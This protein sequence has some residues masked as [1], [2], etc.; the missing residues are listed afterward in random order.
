MAQGAHGTQRWIEQAKEQKT[1]I[2]FRQQLASGVLLGWRLD[3]RRQVGLQTPAK[4]LEQFPALQIA[5]FNRLQGRGHAPIK[6]YCTNLY[7]LQSSYGA[8]TNPLQN[9]KQNASSNFAEHHWGIPLSC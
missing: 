1:K 9:R 4:L 8:V 3:R 6:A 5:F 7:K 2:I